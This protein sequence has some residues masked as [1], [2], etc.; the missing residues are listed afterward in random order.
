MARGTF[1]AVT[2]TF[3]CGLR[4][5]ELHCASSEASAVAA[6]GLSCPLACGILVPRDP[7]LCALL[8]KVDS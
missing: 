5:L 1:F 8:W 3:H 2:R 6:R 4:T 7:T